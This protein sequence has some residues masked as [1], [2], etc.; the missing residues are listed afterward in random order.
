VDIGDSQIQPLRSSRRNNVRGVSS[1]IQPS[2]L[3]WLGDE[4]AHARDAFL[5]DRALGRTPTNA[6]R[7]SSA[8]FSPDSF[9]RPIS[10]AIVSRTL[11]VESGYSWRPHTE[12][13]KS[14]LVVRIDQLVGCRRSLSEDAEPREG[15]RSFVAIQ[16]AVGNRWQAGAV[17]AVAAGNEIT[18]ELLPFAMV[19]EVNPGRRRRHVVQAHVPG[20]KKDGA[21]SLEPRVN[22]V[23]DQL[24]LC[25]NGDTPA[26]G[27]VMQIDAMP[28]STETELDAAMNETFPLQALAYSDFRQ[29]IDGAL[30]QYSGAHSTL[31]MLPRV[32][33]EHY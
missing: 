26:T 25:I 9:V 30:F 31:D 1:E 11:E 20:V 16:D 32:E 29:Q 19:I 13:S 17:R 14:S 28:V 7:H 5:D 22:Q 23:F 33:I 3:H 21:A 2:V 27:E 12:Q 24:V 18:G 10:N 4:A 8:E 6:G 15:V